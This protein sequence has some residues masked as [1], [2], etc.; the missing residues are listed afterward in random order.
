[1]SN[2]SDIL[3]NC[4][5]LA[6]PSAGYV[7]LTGDTG[8]PSIKED[9]VVAV[10]YPLHRDERDLF[11]SVPKPCLLFSLAKVDEVPHQNCDVVVFYT[12]LAQLCDDGVAFHNDARF[13][14]RLKWESSLRRFFVMGN[15]RNAV[16][17]SSTGFLTNCFHGATDVVPNRKQFNLFNDC[18]YAMALK[19]KVIEPI[20]TDG[21][22]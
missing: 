17:S 5:S 16:A 19:F 8:A 6:V 1:M 2:A 22:V 14:S 9:Q 13:T 18:I 3:D 20:D 21:R 4:V 10:S 15:L 7:D 12:V 11:S